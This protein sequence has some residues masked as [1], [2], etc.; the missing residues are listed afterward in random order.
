[1]NAPYPP[2]AGAASGPD[3]TTLYGVLGLVIGLLCCGV[4]GIVLGWLS[5]REARRHNSSPVLGWLAIALSVVNIV[6]SAILRATNRYPW[7]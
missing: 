2:P 7:G 4:V 6:A 3:R 5:I 1:M